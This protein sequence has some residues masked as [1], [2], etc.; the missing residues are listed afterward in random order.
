MKFMPFQVAKPQAIDTKLYLMPASI[1]YKHS[2]AL[3]HGL[4]E[5][6]DG[7]RYVI[8]QMPAVPLADSL[9]FYRPMEEIIV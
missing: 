9:V 3:E 1:I 2:L 8:G 6:V 4:A 5:L 7:Q